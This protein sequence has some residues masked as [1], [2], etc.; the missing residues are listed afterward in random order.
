MHTILKLFIL[1]M[2]LQGCHDKGYHPWILDV[3]Y[4][5]DSNCTGFKLNG[6]PSQQQAGII[7]DCLGNR[8]MIDY[9]DNIPSL[10]IIF[11][12]LGTNDAANNVPINEYAE[13]LQNKLDSAD[14]DIYCVLPTTASDLTWYDV[15]PYRIKMTELCANTIDPLDYGVTNGSGDGTHWRDEDHTRFLPAILNV[16]DGL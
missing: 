6:E 2:I 8:Q 7:V 16:I 3:G 15:T 9:S 12:A 13:S 1:I 4:I 10:R 11:L 14:S 5:G